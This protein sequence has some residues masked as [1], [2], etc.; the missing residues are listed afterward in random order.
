MTC[1]LTSYFWYP[2]L[3]QM[4]YQEIHSPFKTDL[5]LEALSISDSIIQALNNDITTYTMGL[6][7]LV[8]LIF[9]LFILKEMEKKE[10]II[11]VGVVSTWVCVTNLFPWFLFQKT[12]IS[13]LQFPWRIL[14]IQIFFLQ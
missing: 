5:Q 11:Y 10:K 13:L 2:M 3:Q 14:G 7:G 1:A 9:P 4:N 12:P 6:L 8:A